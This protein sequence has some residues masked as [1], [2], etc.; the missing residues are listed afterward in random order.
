MFG[1]TAEEA[2]GRRLLCVPPER[3]DEY[4]AFRAEVLDGRPFTARET[5][6]IR[7]DGTRLDMSI[8]TAPIHDAAGCAIGL[9]ALYVDVGGRKHAEEALRQSQEQ[10]RQAQKMEAVGRLAGGVAHDFNNLLSAILELQRDGAR[11]PAGL[12]TRAATTSSR[13]GAPATA[14]RE[15]THQLLAFSRRQLLQL[16][17]PR[18]QHRRRR[19]RPDAPP[20]HRRG[21]RARRPCS[22]PDL[23]DASGPIPASS[24]RS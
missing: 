7:K 12:A 2:I 4:D 17:S 8:S 11:R 5:V 18:P 9:V 1:W 16:R 14:R 21:H 13:S 23:A 10:L 22:P 24:S 3:Q 19:R 20:G 6:R 15:L